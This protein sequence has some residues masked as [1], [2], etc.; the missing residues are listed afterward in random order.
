MTEQATHKRLDR[1]ES[2]LDI[3]TDAMVKLA[4]TEEKLT[5]LKE[6]QDMQFDRH[7]RFSAKLDEIEKKVDDNAHTVQLINKVTWIAVIA[8]MGSIVAQMF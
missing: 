4:R 7:N 1:I 6:H 5:A 8:V 2:K 3:L